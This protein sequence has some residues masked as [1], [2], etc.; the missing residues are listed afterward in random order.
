MPEHRGLP[1]GKMPSRN[2]VVPGNWDLMASDYLWSKHT[3]FADFFI[4]FWP[5]LIVDWFLP[6][7]SVWN[8]IVALKQ[9]I[10]CNVHM[11]WVNHGCTSGGWIRSL[12]LLIVSVLL[13]FIELSLQPMFVNTHTCTAV[14][15]RALSQHAAQLQCYPDTCLTWSS[16]HHWSS[17]QV[18]LQLMLIFRSGLPLSL[19]FSVTL[20][21]SVSQYKKGKN[22]QKNNFEKRNA[23]TPPWNSLSTFFFFF[24]K[25]FDASVGNQTQGSQVTGIHSTIFKMMAS[26]WQIIR[27]YWQSVLPGIRL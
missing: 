6:T 16:T 10:C 20:S 24:Y 26:L 21:P 27:W 3:C 5:L 19:S 18:G 15:V 9:W 13:I 17:A 7:W 22:A 4:F 1:V 2:H 23:V 8:V 25:V 11:G 12:L 14:M